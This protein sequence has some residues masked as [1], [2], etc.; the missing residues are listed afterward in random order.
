MLA[1]M[2][3][4]LGLNPF[5]SS[6]E[7]GSVGVGRSD[8]G[9]FASVGLRGLKVGMVTGEG[10]ID[11]SFSAFSSF[12]AP[13]SLSSSCV[14]RGIGAEMEREEVAGSRCRG[15]GF[16][17]VTLEVLAG[18]RGRVGRWSL[19]DDVVVLLEDG[20]SPRRCAA[21]TAD[22]RSGGMRAWIEVMRAA[23][24]EKAQ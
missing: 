23:W 10:E 11:G 22:V 16:F 13:E 15:R 18:F 5:P 6:S 21:W 14:G 2:F 9:R 12:S 7:S 4:S 19:T 17:I 3:R 20:S 24:R 1:A 8:K